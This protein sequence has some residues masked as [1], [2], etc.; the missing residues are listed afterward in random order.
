M[1]DAHG[2]K[3]A[4]AAVAQ[5]IEDVA[6]RLSLASSPDNLERAVTD[7]LTI[8]KNARMGVLDA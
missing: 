1:P 8:A 3:R 6:G 5:A 7:L 4:L 2:D